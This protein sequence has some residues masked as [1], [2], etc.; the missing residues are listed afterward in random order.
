MILWMPWEHLAREIFFVLYYSGMHHD[1]QCN[2]EG[3]IQTYRDLLDLNKGAFFVKDFIVA[4]KEDV[5]AH[6]GV[7]NG[8]WGDKR[9]H[10]LCESF[11][12]KT[13]RR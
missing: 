2:T 9:D 7:Q 11:V 8:G 1:G 4:N 12:K 13:N 5:T 6:A 3:I 10:E